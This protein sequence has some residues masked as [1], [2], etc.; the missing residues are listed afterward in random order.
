ML[1]PWLEHDIEPR[2]R[3]GAGLVELAE[4]T[5]VLALSL[6]GPPRKVPLPKQK[7]GSK[8]CE[9]PNTYS[10]WHLLNIQ[11]HPDRKSTS[12][13]I[14]DTQFCNGSYAFMW[15]LARE[16]RDAVTR[17]SDLHQALESQVRLS[18]SSVSILTYEYASNISRHH[19][20]LIVKF[21]IIS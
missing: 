1:A 18:V 8:A 7:M 13:N 5:S 11:F 21:W 10:P 19:S 2:N 6:E 12:R 15:S 20:C 14:A 4:C 17:Y 16:Y 3:R 9:L